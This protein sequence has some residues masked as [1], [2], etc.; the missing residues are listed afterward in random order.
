[1]DKQLRQTNGRIKSTWQS[2]IDSAHTFLTH[3]IVK[4]KEQPWGPESVES[5]QII[6]MSLTSE[7]VEDNYSASIFQS[8][9]HKKV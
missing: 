6:S 5:L 2:T 3:L 4:C 9:L 8:K 7:T 1:M